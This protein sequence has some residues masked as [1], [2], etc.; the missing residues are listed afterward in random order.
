MSIFRR[1]L[2]NLL[3]GEIERGELPDDLPLIGAWCRI[4]PTAML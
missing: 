2:C 3:G 1:I 4:S